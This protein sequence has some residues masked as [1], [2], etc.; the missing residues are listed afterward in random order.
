MS[1]DNPYQAGSSSGT[2]MPVM[3]G[4]DPQR[5]AVRSFELLGRGRNLLGD[6]YWLM[7]GICLVSLLI[8]SA[9]PFGLILGAM[10]VGIYLCFKQI[11]QFGKT[12]FGTA[13]KGFDFFVDSMLVM[14]ISTALSFA[15]ILPLY[16]LMGLSTALALA[17]S[18]NNPEISMLILVIMVPLM[19]CLF[20][21]AIGM[22][23]MPIIFAFQLI[24]DH[25]LK[26]IDAVKLSWHGS[27][28][29]LFG[30][31]KHLFVL[32][33]LS[34]L[35]AM[36]CY[37]PVFL[38]IPISFASMFVLY[39][40]IFGPGGF[41]APPLTTPVTAGYAASPAGYQPPPPP[42]QQTPPPTNSI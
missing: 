42:P 38:F 5:V 11:E 4:P 25:H 24:A 14:L 32:S 8:G 31:L 33:F 18:E 15:V 19:V 27:R 7:V 6:Q 3:G 12:E 41:Q 39:R 34:M 23:Y 16:L 17:L 22:V 35:A 13:F 30:I 29:N 26:A 20:A 37:L 36:L 9:V 2:P 10:V 40:D 21:V 1:T 28:K